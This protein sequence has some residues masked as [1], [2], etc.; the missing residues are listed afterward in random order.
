MG[1]PEDEE[2]VVDVVLM[3]EVLPNEMTNFT[4]N[5]QFQFL[6]F[7]KLNSCNDDEGGREQCMFNTT[8]YS[9]LKDDAIHYIY[10][11]YNTISH[12]ARRSTR[13]RTTRRRIARRRRGRMRRTTLAR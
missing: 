13:R 2:E 1:E 9:V 8:P 4:K 10:A 7:L 3:R 5:F 6:I 12:N 11:Y